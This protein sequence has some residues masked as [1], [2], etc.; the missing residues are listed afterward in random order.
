M[1]FTFGSNL[2]AVLMDQAPADAVALARADMR[3][4]D[5][6]P[7]E[8]RAAFANS[9]YGVP[10]AETIASVIRRGASDEVK[11][12]LRDRGLMPCDVGTEGVVIETIRLLDTR[13][14]QRI[15]AE[16]AS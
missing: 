8:V 15:K 6:Q 7:A 10:V 5:D 9:L 16:L 12:V 11:R 3:V 1:R 4:F 14:S 13:E 2:C